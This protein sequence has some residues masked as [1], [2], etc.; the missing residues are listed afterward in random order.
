MN[1]E[2]KIKFGFDLMP[3]REL[4]LNSADS[5]LVRHLV[6]IEPTINNCISCGS[7]TGSCTRA[8][9][10]VS[11]R[12]ALLLIRRGLLNEAHEI[13]ESCIF[14]GKCRFV[15]PQGVNTRRIIYELY[16]FKKLNHAI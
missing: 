14:C 8:V 4:N 16:R 6:T 1:S 3:Q 10:G 5:P 13:M 2:F 9:S 11:F 15:C 12:K 7:C